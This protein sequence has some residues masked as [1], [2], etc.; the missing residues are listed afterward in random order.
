MSHAID[1]LDADGTR[2]R[3]EYDTNLWRESMDWARFHGLDPM[4]IPAGSTIERDPVTFEIRY[5]EYAVDPRDGLPL[6]RQNEPVIE[7][8][9]ARGEG[10]PLPF[11]TH[12]EEAH[13]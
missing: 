4:L 3:V 1:L 10:P 8:R 2:L 13:G 7:H 5:D 12:M 9:V 6:V 11:P